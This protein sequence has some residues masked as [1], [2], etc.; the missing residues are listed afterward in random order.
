MT[1]LDKFIEVYGFE[2][3]TS[4][5]PV[6]CPAKCEDCRY[7]SGDPNYHCG[8]CDWWD[9]EYKDGQERKGVLVSRIPVR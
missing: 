3:D 5:S 8:S 2:P 4:G 1:N 6:P 7:Y 9:E